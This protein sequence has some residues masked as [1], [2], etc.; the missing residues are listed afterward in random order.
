MV[1]GEQGS[2]FLSLLLGDQTFLNEEFPHSRK[3]KS[4]ASVGLNRSTDVV[5]VDHTDL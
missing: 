2:I 4:E 1:P 3:G 5:E